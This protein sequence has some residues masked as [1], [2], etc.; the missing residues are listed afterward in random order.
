MDTY[1]I[2]GALG[3]RGVF[4]VYKSVDFFYPRQPVNAIPQVN[5]NIN[6]INQI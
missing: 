6:N 1:A 3:V 4:G 2:V 5:I